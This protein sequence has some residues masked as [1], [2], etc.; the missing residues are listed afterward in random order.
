LNIQKLEAKQEI[1]LLALKKK[2]DATVAGAAK[3]REDEHLK[4]L[5]K[6]HNTRKDLET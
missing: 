6:Y 2:I 4:L 3:T 1:E 5:T